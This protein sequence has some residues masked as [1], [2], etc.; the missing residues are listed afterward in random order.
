MTAEHPIDSSD[1]N[2][3]KAG[4]P[5]GPELGALA[6]AKYSLV[7]G[8]VYAWARCFSL[9]GLY[10]LG[11]VF[12]TCE[13]LINYKRRRRFRERLSE[14]LGPAVKDM[15]M[16]MS[17]AC[18]RY[19]IR[20]RCDK[21]F[22]LIFDKLPREQILKR[23]RFFGRDVLDEALQGNRGAYVAL[24]HYGSHHVAG[25]HMALLGYKVAGVRDRNEA[26]LRKFIQDKF[27]DTFPEFRASRIYYS[28]SFP[29]DLF[30]CFQEGFI[31]GSAI[32]VERDRG[33]HLK[34]MPVKMFGRRQEFLTGPMQ[35]ALRCGAPILQGFVVSRRNFYFRLIVI[36]PLADPK[37]SADNPDVL[38]TAIQRYADNIEKHVR[39]YPCHISRG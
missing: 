15:A 21:L 28:D 37:T 39:D 10:L 23:I 6:R 22:Y 16:P 17:R 36:G 30:R 14:T 4:S 29:R 38:A 8:F 3:V 9:N 32:D 25:L 27:L 5:E 7:Q 31:L 19:F 33:A 20:S 13:W 26:P 34:T 18:R 24:S 12:A 35:I 1:L 2:P 11:V